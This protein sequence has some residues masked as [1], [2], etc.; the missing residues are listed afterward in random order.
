MGTIYATWDERYGYGEEYQFGTGTTATAGLPTIGSPNFDSGKT[1]IDTKKTVGVPY[2]KTLE[3]AL[4]TDT[5]IASIDLEAKTEELNFLL[6]SLFQQAWTDYST[7]PY[8]KLYI[9]P[10]HLL[11]FIGQNTALASGTSGITLAG[12]NYFLQTGNNTEDKGVKAG[13]WL[14]IS[15]QDD[16]GIYRITQIFGVV[17]YCANRLTGANTSFIGDTGATWAIYRGKPFFFSLLRDL[18][19]SDVENHR[20]VSAIA[21]TIS[22]KGDSGGAIIVT[23]GIIGRSLDT[24]VDTSLAAH[25]FDISTDAI[26]LQQELNV[27]V[28]V[29][30]TSDSTVQASD[31]TITGTTQNSIVISGTSAN[32]LTEY[33]AGNY[34][35]IKEFEIS[36]SNDA[37]DFVESAGDTYTITTGTNDYLDWKED[38]GSEKTAIIKAGTYTS[39]AL[40]RE[41]VYEMNRTAGIDA[42]YT[43]TYNAS[44]A[45]FNITASGGGVTTISLLFL[46]GTNNAKSIDTTLG[47]SHTDHTGVLTYDSDSQA[48]EAD[49]TAFSID[50]PDGNYSGIELALEIEKQMNI[51]TT[52]TLDYSVIYDLA[53]NKFTFY[54]RSETPGELW[55]NDASQMASTIG[56]TAQQ[57]A[58]TILTTDTAK[59]VNTGA[60][61]I[62]SISQSTNTTIVVNDMEGGVTG[63]A[64]CKVYA[65]RPIKVNL[66]DLTI[67]NNA[68][69]K[70]YNSRYP[71][72]YIFGGFTLEGSISTPWGSWA[73]DENLNLNNFIN[74][75]SLP[76]MFV[77]GDSGEAILPHKI[78]CDA[79]SDGNLAIIALIKYNG[80][81]VEGDDEITDTLP[82]ITVDKA[83]FYDIE[84]V[85]VVLAEGTKKHWINNR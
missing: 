37:L 78:K 40:A 41:I 57:G 30:D 61:L 9:P 53:S 13:D 79:S 47:Y 16:A 43:V 74:G 69:T 35:T 65:W 48:G 14:Y 39:G 1:V 45:F 36:S 25:T 76:I 80:A 77:W 3:F 70:H 19:I 44:T 7:S 62:S 54:P 51:N 60:Y 26:K 12:T 64:L 58:T 21:N 82:F 29:P 31:A 83:D 46:T 59:G 5:P 73:N 49:N 50:V 27:L 38:A 56:Y 42:T 84:P 63:A 67:S 22:I 15:D 24:N 81:T 8:T 85:R 20:I 18:G 55:L 6:Y 28:G 71:Q 17:C 33:A 11:S 66:F 2:R 72:E 10:R 75:V 34:I 52:A 23:S 68:V 32:F 4:A